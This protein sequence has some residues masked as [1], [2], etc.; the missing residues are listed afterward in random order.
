M[1]GNL[2]INIHELFYNKILNVIF[3]IN[4]QKL[5][6]VPQYHQINLII[7]EDNCIF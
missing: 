1:H 2:F 6:K 3:Q 7:N 4:F 5:F